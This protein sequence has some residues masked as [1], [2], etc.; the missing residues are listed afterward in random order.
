MR[1]N[2]DPLKYPRLIL[3]R[4]AMKYIYELGHFF[5]VNCSLD[6]SFLI[7][8]MNVADLLPIFSVS[9]NVSTVTYNFKWSST[10]FDTWRLDYNCL[11]LLLLFSDP[12]M[13]TFPLDHELVSQ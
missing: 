5:G 12:S 1:S 3:T 11:K 13:G 4:R 7:L 9:R 10:A 6:V 8:K 2:T